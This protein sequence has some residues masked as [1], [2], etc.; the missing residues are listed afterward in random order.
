MCVDCVVEGGAV[1]YMWVEEVRMDE[2]GIEVGEEGRWDRGYGRWN[3]GD[4]SVVFMG[5]NY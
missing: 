4:G 2:R 3:G 1:V 5:V